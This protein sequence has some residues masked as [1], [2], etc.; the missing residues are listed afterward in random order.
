M[1]N[2]YQFK[3]HFKNMKHRNNSK[4]L[5]FVF[6]WPTAGLTCVPYFMI[7]VLTYDAMLVTMRLFATKYFNIVVFFFCTD[8]SISKIHKLSHN[9]CITLTNLK[10]LFEWNQIRINEQSYL[11]SDFYFQNKRPTAV[12]N[13][14]DRYVPTL[15]KSL[16][17]QKVVHICC[18]EDHT[19]AL[20]KVQYLKICLCFDFFNVFR[21]RCY[22]NRK[23]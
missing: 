12:L 22:L 11:F 15:L 17:T 3:E 16:R 21:R 13:L 10:C 19:A 9:V 2:S 1:T 20:T 6:S 4:Q 18:G 8:T 7:Y 14:S 23:Q 5:S